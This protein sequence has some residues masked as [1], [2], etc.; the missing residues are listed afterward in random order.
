MSMHPLI[1]KTTILLIFLGSIPFGTGLLIEKQYHRVQLVITEL[2]PISIQA[3]EYH[4]GWFH[5]KAVS[6]IIFPR[7]DSRIPLI[8][9]IEQV[10]HHGP[11]LNKKHFFLANIHSTLLPLGSMDVPL[12]VDTTF[13][14]TGAVT[15]D[16]QVPH[17]ELKDLDQNI[18]LIGDTIQ[19]HWAF[20]KR[21][22]VL[23]GSV[24]IKQLSL[25]SDEQ[26]VFDLNDF[27]QEQTLYKDLKGRW[28]GRSELHVNQL[29]NN[30]FLKDIPCIVKNI[31]WKSQ[32][33][34]VEDLLTVTHHGSVESLQYQED[35]YG[36]M[37]FTVT[38]PVK[39]RAHIEIPESTL[40]SFIDR[41]LPIGK[42]MNDYLKKLDK[43]KI[44]S[45][46]NGLYTIDFSLGPVIA[47]P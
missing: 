31:Q 2:S 18:A 14:F 19:G 11:F 15:I 30:G 35:L 36:P 4:R 33:E 16:L 1:K 8:V 40:T 3:K 7:K 28:L 5:S 17:I 27:S 47:S 46:T 34:D 41:P 24:S 10:I 42:S 43:D 39:A 6:E 20:S 32:R 25:W 21:L 9:R 45:L 13:E 22:S 23:E 12:I 29:S 26:E 44:L 38:F 37:N